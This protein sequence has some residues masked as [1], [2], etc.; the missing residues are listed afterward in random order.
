MEK[1]EGGSELLR[2]Q[3]EAGS[4]RLMQPSFLKNPIKVW[5]HRGVWPNDEGALKLPESRDRIITVKEA[6]MC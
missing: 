1:V 4:V 6:K 5:K 3:Q 2:T